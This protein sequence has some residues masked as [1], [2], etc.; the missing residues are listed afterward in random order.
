MGEKENNGGIFDKLCEK[1][2]TYDDRGA[3][4]SL[5]IR[6]P[7]FLGLK[8]TRSLTF[9]IHFLDKDIVNQ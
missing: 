8:K 9:D 7:L 1:Y 5:S 6:N 3:C 2:S 4:I